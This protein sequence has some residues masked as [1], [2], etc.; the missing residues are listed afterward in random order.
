MLGFQDTFETEEFMRTYGLDES[1]SIEIEDEA[2]GTDGNRRFNM[3]KEDQ[4]IADQKIFMAL[5]PSKNTTIIEVKRDKKKYLGY[6]GVEDPD[7]YLNNDQVSRRFIVKG[8]WKK[9]NPRYINSVIRQYLRVFE[10]AHGVMEP[11]ADDKEEQEE[12]EDE[13]AEIEPEGAVI[14]REPIAKPN[15]LTLT[16]TVS[17]RPTDG[18]KVVESKKSETQRLLQEEILRKQQQQEEKELRRR[19]EQERFERQKIERE[20]KERER[21]ER[22]RLERERIQREKI[23]REKAELKRQEALELEEFKKNITRARPGLI[24]PLLGSS[25]EINQPELVFEDTELTEFPF[26]TFLSKTIAERYPSENTYSYKMSVFTSIAYQEN[27]KFLDLLLKFIT[28]GFQD[29]SVLDSESLPQIFLYED[30]EFE[31]HSVLKTLSLSYQ[32]YDERYQS[33]D[34]NKNK[35]FNTMGIENQSDGSDNPFYISD[36]D[37]LSSNVVV[38]IFDQ[39]TD[40][41]KRRF[42]SNLGCFG[43]VC[44]SSDRVDYYLSC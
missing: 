16:Q 12:D 13:M 6:E 2:I 37:L 7:I 41:S 19:Q 30:I 33:S 35:G 31:W 5:R 17:M 18:I 14:R 26:F 25:V 8:N 15:P 9:P 44:Q 40:L 10:K 32:L 21:I 24:R 1:Q 28:D 27:I 39:D 23:E 29:I 11:I 43:K 20:R 36:S 22:E 4:A 34:A 3:K 38:F 42:Q